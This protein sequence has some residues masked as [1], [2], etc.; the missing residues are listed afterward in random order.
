MAQ[1]KLYTAEE[2]HAAMDKIGGFVYQFYYF[3]YLLLRMEEGDRVS[4]EKLDD[5]SIEN[6]MCISLVQVKHTIKMWFV[7]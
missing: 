1:K 7:S 4:F 2:Q 3:L 5:A 6:E